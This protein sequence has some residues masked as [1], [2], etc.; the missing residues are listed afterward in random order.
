MELIKTMLNLGREP[1]STINLGS[2][3]AEKKGGCYNFRKKGL[4]QSIR[5]RKI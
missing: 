4:M 3:G 2:A 1:T 5:E